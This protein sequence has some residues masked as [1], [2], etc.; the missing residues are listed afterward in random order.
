MPLAPHDTRGDV[1]IHLLYSKRDRVQKLVGQEK[2]A[3]P[4]VWRERNI[5]HT[6]NGSLWSLAPG[7]SQVATESPNGF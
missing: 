5:L 2:P 7:D 6:I 4:F 3:V 1:I